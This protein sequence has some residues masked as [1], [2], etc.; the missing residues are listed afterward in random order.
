[1]VNE[2]PITPARS[3]NSAEYGR[4]RAS[5]HEGAARGQRRTADAH[6]P[7]QGE[8]AEERLRSQRKQLEAAK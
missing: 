7:A 2:H 6:I 4:P 5:T 3:G 8:T 1:M